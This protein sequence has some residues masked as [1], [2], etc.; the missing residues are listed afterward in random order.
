MRKPSL[1]R[2]DLLRSSLRIGLERRVRNLSEPVMLAW[3]MDSGST[4]LQSRM[5]S[6]KVNLEL[7]VTSYWMSL[8]HHE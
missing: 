7:D 1:G 4:S 6:Q 5:L 8:S 3:I 2:R